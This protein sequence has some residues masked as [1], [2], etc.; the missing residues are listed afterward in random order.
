VNRALNK[1]QPEMACQY[2]CP[3]QQ[4]Q[5]IACDDQD[6]R[7]PKNAQRHVLRA[8]NR[9]HHACLRVGGMRGFAPLPSF[10]S[11]CIGYQARLGKP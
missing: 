11:P 7:P 6:I 4:F 10:P 3:D 8:P 2:A 1:W 5:I 9:T